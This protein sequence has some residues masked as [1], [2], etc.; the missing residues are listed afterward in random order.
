MILCEA[1]RPV[2]PILEP[3]Q[4]PPTNIIGGPRF[5]SE[6]V[7]LFEKIYLQ[8]LP[9]IYEM[10]SKVDRDYDTD[11][12]NETENIV[13]DEDSRGKDKDKIRTQSDSSLTPVKAARVHYQELIGMEL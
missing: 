2:P 5:E 1:A 6:F 13:G 3:V 11:D 9:P 12:K 7:N 4:L 8:Y 10:E